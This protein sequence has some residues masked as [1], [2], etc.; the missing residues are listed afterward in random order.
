MDATLLL[1]LAREAIKSRLDNAPLDLESLLQQQPQ[2]RNDGATFVTLNLNGELRGCIGSLIATRPLYEDLVANARA[3]AFN[4]P[5]F[6]PLSAQEFDRISVEV[7]LLSEPKEIV[8]ENES[9]LRLQVTPFQDGIILQS[10]AA[11]A[12]FLPQ[13]WEQLPDFDEFFA[14]LCHKAGLQRQCLEQ[15][16]RIYR[17]G[18]EKFS[19]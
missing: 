13:V 6:P 1:Q 15:H 16:P 2:L 11:Q 12:T 3:A 4:D 19:E 14:H 7:S 9:D 17:Y 5:R 10:G 18:V 8:Y